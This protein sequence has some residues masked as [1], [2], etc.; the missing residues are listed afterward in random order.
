MKTIHLPPEVEAVFREF[1]TCEFTTLGR[2]GAPVTWP[3]AARYDPKNGRFLIT[4]SIALPQKV[5]NVRRNP[6]V[7]L[8]FSNPTGSGLA[9]PPAVLVQG[10]ATAPDEVVTSV[11]GLEDY[12]RETIFRRQPASEMPDNVIVHKLVDW[13]YMRILIWITPRV[14][15]WWPAGDFSKIPSSLEVSRVE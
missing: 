5:Y 7:A 4:S 3:T 6:H 13:Y 10:N 14:I 9:S 2:N 1:R 11:E 12:W 8:L 15:R